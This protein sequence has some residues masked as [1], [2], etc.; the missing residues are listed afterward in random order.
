MGFKWTNKP[1][2]RFMQQGCIVNRAWFVGA[3]GSFSCQNCLFSSER[4]KF[5]NQNQS[6]FCCLGLAWRTNI[7]N[8][9][10]EYLKIFIISPRRLKFGNCP[11][12]QGKPYCSW[13]VWVKNDEKDQ[14]QDCIFCKVF[15]FACVLVKSPLLIFI[16]WKTINT[17]LPQINDKPLSFRNANCHLINSLP[18]SQPDKKGFCDIQAPGL[19]F[20][21]WEAIR[22]TRSLS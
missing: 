3:E 11:Q 9:Y 17:N 10:R 8:Y 5:P 22:A 7:W 4:F 1:F 16:R 15:F 19:T 14:D 20:R 6:Y 12:L 21:I 13:F 2:E 18:T